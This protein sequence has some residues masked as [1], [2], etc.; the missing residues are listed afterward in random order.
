MRVLERIFGRRAKS[1]GNEAFDRAMNT[2]DDLIARMQE[3]SRSNDA[4]RAVMAD[5][6][7]QH[8]NVPFLVTVYEAVQEM[9]SSTD[10]RPE[11]HGTLA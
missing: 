8:H 1:R 11:D 3:A 7:A 5:I 6:W 10:Q 4:F 2:S 9:K